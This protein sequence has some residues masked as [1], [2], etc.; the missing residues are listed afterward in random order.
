MLEQDDMDFY[1]EQTNPEGTHYYQ[2]DTL[3]SFQEVSAGIKIK[4]NP[5]TLIH[6]KLSH[7][8]PIINSVFAKESK[9]TLCLWW[10]YTKSPNLLMQSYR[11]L[12]LAQNVGSFSQ[13][14]STMHS[15][16]VNV[17]YADNQNNIAWW[18]VGKLLQRPKHVN[19]FNFID[20]SKKENDP[21]GYYPFSENPHLMNPERGFVYSANEQPG[22][23][24]DSTWY[25][26]Y[27]VVSNRSYRIHE[28]LETRKDWTHTAMKGMMADAIS[29]MDGCISS[30]MCEIIQ[31]L[32]DG[33]AKTDLNIL[34]QMQN[35]DGSHEL[36]ETAPT[37]YYKWLYHM[38]SMAM[39]DEMGEE[40]FESFLGTHWKFRAITPLIENEN[41]PWWD[42]V[43]TPEK[44]S[45]EQIIL[46]AYQLTIN[47][48]NKQLGADT[49]DWQW[50][51]VRHIE[52]EHPLSQVPLLG[53]VFNAGP[54]KIK[55]ASETIGAAGFK[56]SGD[57]FYEVTGG[58]QMR[59]VHDLSHP[60]SSW[61][62]LPLGQS[63]HPFSEHYDD[64][65]SDY[66]E[67]DFELRR[68]KLSKN[69]HVTSE[70][71]FLPS[72]GSN[73]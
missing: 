5:D 40:R 56:L 11:E 34:E 47:E 15:P 48:L 41:A 36:K 8:G 69:K 38:L 61:N 58:S 12:G 13:A 2:D 20:G 32:A 68:F 6:W 65:F 67:F 25:P 26:G 30:R 19:S 4:D 72:N 24:A 50:S 31:Y 23:M 3:R 22:M 51:A 70:L 37:V 33:D 1:I 63:G 60:D 14:L 35:W 62:V 57:G 49:D 18:A 52:I 29:P 16:G 7:H 55:G 9:H 73:H 46:D 17:I 28:M 64:Q 66:C 39:V 71:I 44:E 45:R 27:Y 53:M 21:I 42:N 54:A 59:I 10:D 43:T